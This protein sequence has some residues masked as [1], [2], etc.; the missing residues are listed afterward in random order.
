MFTKSTDEKAWSVAGCCHPL[1]RD[2]ERKEDV[3]KP[4]DQQ[5][6]TDEIAANC[7]SKPLNAIFSGVDDNQFRLIA[8]CESA[9]DAWKTLQIVHK[10]IETVRECKLQMLTTRFEELRMH[11]N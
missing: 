9:K 7:Y 4:E 10:G 5:D 2:I 8:S 6:A 3:L 11:D 1:M